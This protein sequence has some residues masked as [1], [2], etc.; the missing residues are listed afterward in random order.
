MASYI[1]VLKQL[2]SI[3]ISENKF[4]CLTG[5]CGRMYVRVCMRMFRLCFLLHS[6]PGVTGTFLTFPLYHTGKLAMSLRHTAVLLYIYTHLIADSSYGSVQHKVKTLS[7]SI[8][9][10]QLSNY[11]KNGKMIYNISE[12]RSAYFVK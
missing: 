6:S 7:L 8:L 9:S 12:V 11:I 1:D 4:V 2:F 3:F 10:P 5:K